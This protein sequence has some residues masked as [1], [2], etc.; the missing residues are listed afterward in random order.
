MD[1]DVIFSEQ[2]EQNLDRIISYCLYK[3]KNTQAAMNILKDV[4]NTLKRLSYMA[5]GLKL[6]ENARLRDLGYRKIHLR[7][8]SYFLL[9]RIEDNKVYV[10]AVYHD[11]QDYEGV[12]K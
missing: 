6:C 7:Q 9:Y 11:L 4:E 8:H 1:F 3:L 2:A 10:D 5:D 12:F